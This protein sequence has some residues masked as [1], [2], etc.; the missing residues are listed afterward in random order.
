MR[1]IYLTLLSVSAILLGSLQLS[2]QVSRYAFTPASGTYAP[3][4]GGVVSS[5]T[6]DDGTQEVPIGFAFNFGGVAYSYAVISA[7]G[8]IKLGQTAGTTFGASWTNVLSNTS[9]NPVIAPLWDDNNA[10]GATIT[11]ITE[12][13][14]PSRTFSVEWK[15]LHLGGAGSAT[16]PLGTFKVK[17]TETSNNIEFSYGNIAALTASTFSVGVV[18][19]SSFVSITPGAP[20]TA[21]SS[22]AANG[23]SSAANLPSGTVYT[24]ALPACDPGSVVAG[25][26]ASS[27]PSACAG[28]AITLSVTGGTAVSTG[29]TYQWETSPDGTAWTPVSGATNPTYTVIQ[30]VPTQ[31]RRSITCGATTVYSTAVSVTQNPVIDCYCDEELTA[32]PS[33]EDIITNFT[34]TAANGTSFSQSSTTSPT[35]YTR[36]QNTPFDISRQ[37]TV[38]IAITVGPDFSWGQHSA[39]WV[40]FNR[41]NI[42]D[43]N[44]NVA[45][46]E[47]PSDGETTLTYTFNV[48]ATAVLG[49]T[50]IRI[51]GGSDDGSA[52]TADGACIPTD[53]GETE[54][55][56]VNI[57]PAPSC[58]TPT[59]AVFS[60]LTTTTA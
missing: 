46:S 45:L 41:D 47:D 17:I 34:I 7:N 4:T 1:K 44:E 12:G 38:T 3:V 31:Y 48:P 6:T 2:A 58:I 16:S 15:N 50:R 22:T 53:Y 27:L 35:N 60:A 33:S 14:A 36:Y 26:T 57:V 24:L 5:I 25:A 52:Y 21:S 23:L 20:A 37:T 8:A 51:R 19:L 30:L 59:G 9:A 55:Y 49:N 39:A 43:E 56:I 18:D 11:Y 10:S 29:L 42:F 54:D 40:D 13:A 32:D 28:A